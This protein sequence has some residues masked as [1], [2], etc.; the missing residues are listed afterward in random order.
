MVC[1]YVVALFMI[2]FKSLLCLYDCRQV[3]QR[4]FR[5]IGF[6]F[7]ASGFAE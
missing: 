7:V 6:F 3:V 5:L 4:L 2:V 1:S